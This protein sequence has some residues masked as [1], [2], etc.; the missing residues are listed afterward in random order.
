MPRRSAGRKPAPPRR[1]LTARV[2][3]L[4]RRWRWLTVA[5]RY[6]ATFAA[7]SLIRHLIL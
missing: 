6:A 3:A 1:S 4:E 5:A 7:G 2:A